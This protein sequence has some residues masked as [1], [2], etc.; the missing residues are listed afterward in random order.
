[1]SNLHIPNFNT[2]ADLFDRLIV[3]VNKLAFFENKKRETQ[4]ELHEILCLSDPESFNRSKEIALT[5]AHWDNASR[6]ECEIRNLLKREIDKVFAEAIN[7]NEYKAL[8]DFRTFRAAN[9]SIA[10]ILAD[11]CDE[12]G[13][14]TKAKLEEYW[15]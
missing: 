14:T 3:C 6:N 4:A 7:N 15:T 12:I 11:Q 10:D 8:P 1:M 2:M 9:K 5:I 13:I